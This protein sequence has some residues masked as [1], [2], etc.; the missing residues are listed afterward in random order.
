MDDI[1]SGY[2]RRWYFSLGLLC[3]LSLFFSCNRKDD[4][5]KEPPL[6]TRK[7]IVYMVG[8]NTL[9]DYVDEDIN[10]MERGWKDSFDGDLIVYVDQKRVAPYILKISSDRTN[11]IVS[12]EVMKYSEQNSSSVD[13]MEKVLSDIKSMYPAQSYGLILWSH[14]SGWLPTP[15]TTTRAFGDDGG[16]SMEITELAKLSGRYDFFIFDACDMMGVEVAYELRYNTDYIVGSVTE[17]MAGGFPYHDIMEYLFEKNANLISVCEKFMEL[18]RSYPSA[19]M[20][21]AA[22]SVVKTENLENIASASKNLIQKYK[23]NIANLDVSQIQKYDSEKTTLF[24]DFLDF[25]ENIAEND[26]ELQTLRNQLLSTVIFEDHTPSILN[27]FEIKKS[28]GLSC[29][30]LGQN[31]SLDYSYKNMTWYKATYGN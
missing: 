30:I 2:G 13:V 18:Y 1:K 27:I 25:M 5:S 4:K 20:Q 29:Y 16:K 10:E 6:K 9:D 21:T 19:E 8:D 15:S 22:L 14:A 17:I 26:S 23:N 3:L 11:S 12:K 31:R 7:I 28:C 24:F